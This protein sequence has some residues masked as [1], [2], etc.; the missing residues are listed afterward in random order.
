[1]AGIG[2]ELYK[3]LHKGTLSSIV[4][5][6][7][8]GMIIVAGPWILSVLTIYIIQTYTFGAIA[9]NPSLFTVSIVYVYAFSLF[10]SGGFHYVFSRYIADQL[11]IEN[12]E[13]IPTALLTAI[14]IITILSILPA[15]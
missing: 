3:I 8:L 5:A 15:L 6:F 12:Y 9:D 10:L 7:F 4:Q 13:T 11:Y 14:I 2:F 1:M